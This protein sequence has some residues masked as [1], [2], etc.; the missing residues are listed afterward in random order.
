MV[1]THQLTVAHRIRIFPHPL[2][3]SFS[4]IVIEVRL[5]KQVEAVD[6]TNERRFI[7]IIILV[8]VESVMTFM[9]AWT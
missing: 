7:I 8:F 4:Q 1:A 6:A 3:T 5:Q 2:R 9:A